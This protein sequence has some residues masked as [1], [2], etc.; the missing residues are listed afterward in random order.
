[1]SILN[2]TLSRAQHWDLAGIGASTI[3]V[4]HC[5]L[6]PML[7]VF[8]PSLEVL[9]KQTHT[10]FALTILGIGMFAFWPGYQR[11]RRWNIVAAAVGGFVLISLGAVA[12]EGLLSDSVEE[13]VTVVGGATLIIAHLRNAFFC[14]DCPAC[15]EPDC[16]P[17]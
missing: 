4:L 2:L 1:M 9:E 3:C 12:P 8:L 13:T 11:H 16:S 10:A 14:R 7:V 5:L 17:N 15:G 6:A